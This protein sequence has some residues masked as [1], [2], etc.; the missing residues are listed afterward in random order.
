MRSLSIRGFSL[1]E[2]LVALA[3]TASVSAALLPALAIA[4]RLHRESAIE[5]EAAVIGEARLELLASDAAN[6]TIG[7]GGRLDARAE[8]WH[9]CVDRSGA[10]VEEHAA[11]FEL[12]WQIVS[13]VAPAGVTAVSVRVIPVASRGVSITLATVVAD[14]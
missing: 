9:A 7:A 13:L 1:V 6:G 10:V 12:R 3:L 11:S 8:G 5:T 14:E 4:S 2:T